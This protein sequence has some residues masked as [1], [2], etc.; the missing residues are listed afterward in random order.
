M[1]QGS[2]HALSLSKSNGWWLF[3]MG[4]GIKY[5]LNVCSDSDTAE[6]RAR[7]LTVTSA[8][9]FQGATPQ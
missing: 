7:K 6:T 3:H 5:D 1:P 2:P 8:S 4:T 9:L